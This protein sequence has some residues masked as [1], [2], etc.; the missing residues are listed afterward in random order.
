[1]LMTTTNALPI[2][3]ILKLELFITMQL[4]AMT[5]IHALTNL[6]TLLRD[7]FS[8]ML[9]QPIAMTKTFVP[10]T[11]AQATKSNAST[12]QLI[13][14]ITIHAPPMLAILFPDVSIFL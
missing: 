10:S 5:K 1:M 14:M 11:D 4:F 13:A 7:V 6:A 3:V 9:E 2:I 12:L 8:L